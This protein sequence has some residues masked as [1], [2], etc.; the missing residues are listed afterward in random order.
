MVVE[1]STGKLEHRRFY[2]IL[3]YLKRGDVLVLNDTKVIPA[4]LLGRKD[5][6]GGKAEVLL[7]KPL[8]AGWEYW[9]A[10]VRPGRRLKTGD[11][12]SYRF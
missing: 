7:V 6:T 1:K 5:R 8:D 2:E 12:N 4:R 10:M 3:D 9:E 11:Q